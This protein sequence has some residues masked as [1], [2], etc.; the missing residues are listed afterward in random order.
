VSA[1]QTPAQGD[2][3]VGSVEKAEEIAR[4]FHRTYEEQAPAH[5]YETRE[6]SA[7]PW[8]QVPENNRALMVATVHGVLNYQRAQFYALAKR[9]NLPPTIA[10]EIATRMFG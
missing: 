10:I 5:G 7:K 4:I 9:M 1:P 6:A 3:E 2:P 8:E